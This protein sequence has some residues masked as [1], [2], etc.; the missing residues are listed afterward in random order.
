MKLIT[1]LILEHSGPERA[2]MRAMM[3]VGLEF[4]TYNDAT[5]TVH[6]SG[7]FVTLS[8]DKTTGAR[9]V[10]VV[11]FPGQ[12]FIDQ[13]GFTVEADDGQSPPDGAKPLARTAML[14]V[15][16][17]GAT[18]R[19]SVKKQFRVRR[20]VGGG[21][22][23][24]ARDASVRIGAAR[25]S[26]GVDSSI[27][28]VRESTS[29]DDS[30]H[31]IGRK[32]RT[33]MPYGVDVVRGLRVST[34]TVTSMDADTEAEREIMRFFPHSGLAFNPLDPMARVY[35]PAGE[36]AGNAIN[37]DGV[38]YSDG[39]NNILLSSRAGFWHGHRDPF[40]A[41]S[42]GESD[43]SLCY[44]VS[45]PAWSK[46]DGKSYL[47]V[48]AVYGALSDAHFPAGSAAKSL[49]CQYT[50]PTG[51][52]FST[53]TWANY[54]DA[55][56]RIYPSPTRMRLLRTGPSSL[57]LVLVCSAQVTP[58]PAVAVWDWNIEAP[59]PWWPPTRIARGLQ[60]IIVMWSEDN[61]ATWTQTP[62]ASMGALTAGLNPIHDLFMDLA[63]VVA[64]RANELLLISGAPSA[65]G[66]EDM[67]VCAV[68]PV[69]ATLRATLPA[70]FLRAGLT[71]SYQPWYRV[72]RAVAVKGAVAVQLTPDNFTAASS[73]Q[74]LS[75]PA[76]R[77]L[78]LVSTD[79]GTSWARRE[80]PTPFP[81]RVG[82]IIAMGDANIGV[83]ILSAR[84]DVG[85]GFA[86]EGLPYTLYTSKD[87]GLNWKKSAVSVRMPGETMHDG[88]LSPA[89]Y[90]ANGAGARNKLHNAEAFPWVFV[91]DE[92][93]EFSNMHPGRPWLHDHRFTEPTP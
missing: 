27:I 40:Y 49:T 30:R 36:E 89:Q 31:Y 75:Y 32:Y 93:G 11:E 29:P 85:D 6:I 13:D 50:T 78:L 35:G 87:G 68:S 46:A 48:A 16:M 69:G 37:P 24:D 91:R 43:P 41:S 18:A 54:D 9:C 62:R 82:Q 44:A 39:V 26:K 77:A 76:E 5:S 55:P 56:E 72:V 90:D 2:S 60:N 83:P 57:A 22:V 59:G 7:E 52:A 74:T 84:R 23:N 15:G 73:P 58:G 61:G 81:H 34:V 20:T 25:A 19:M 8:R 67:N 64:L 47:S 71:A 80:F 4:M 3:D 45:E 70:D 14:S 66:G 63:S 88:R 38:T 86:Q 51:I 33:D 92:K 12:S 28:L 1:D 53:V 17:D 42:A 10:T 79:E 21:F 65:S